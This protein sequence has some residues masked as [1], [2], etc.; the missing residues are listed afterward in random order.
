MINSQPP[1]EIS[2]ELAYWMDKKGSLDLD[3]PREEI[4]AF[5]GTQG[6]LSADKAEYKTLQRK[7][8]EKYGKLYQNY[9]SSGRIKSRSPNAFNNQLDK[10]QAFLKAIPYGDFS[11]N[12]WFKFTH[13][14]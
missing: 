4:I 9:P 11:D 5:Y 3:T 8:Q 13:E 14:K 2:L 10:M 6:M 1:L 7:C 12:R